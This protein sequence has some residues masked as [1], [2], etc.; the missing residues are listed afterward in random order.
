MFSTFASLSNSR[1]DRILKEYKYNF[2]VIRIFNGFFKKEAIKM[3]DAFNK[4]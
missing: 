1:F 4:I 3:N 2:K